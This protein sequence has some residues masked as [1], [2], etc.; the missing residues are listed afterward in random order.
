MCS[1]VR[2]AF[3]HT[4]ELDLAA[5]VDQAAPDVAISAELGSDAPH[6]TAMGRI[7]DRLRLR[8]LFACDVDLEDEVRRGIDRALARGMLTAPDGTVSR[9]SLRDAFPGAVQERE[10]AEAEALLDA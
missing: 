10:R 9:W 5:D 1:P 8:V 4:A 2:S 3:A 6:H 7:G